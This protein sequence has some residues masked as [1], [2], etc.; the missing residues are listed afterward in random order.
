MDRSR[1]L[2]LT[3]LAALACAAAGCSFSSPEPSVVLGSGP[4]VTPDP[5][6]PPVPDA[7]PAPEREDCD[8]TP[9]GGRRQDRG[10]AAAAAGR[11][12]AG[13]GLG[14][15][16][17]ERCVVAHHDTGAPA[18][19]HAVRVE[20]DV[21]GDLVDHSVVGAAEFEDAGSQVGIRCEWLHG[22]DDQL[23]TNRVRVLGTLDCF[24]LSVGVDGIDEVADPL[25]HRPAG[26][27]VELGALLG[28]Q[29]VFEG[30]KS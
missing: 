11:A 27:G 20:Q 6:D 5:P 1:S 16:A 17:G 2:S 21:G 24:G 29:L 8:H 14:E 9:D 3:G 4:R 10:D 25:P 23:L 18:N 13:E 12:P 7:P 26:D 15:H 30:G 19:V 22:V 28:S